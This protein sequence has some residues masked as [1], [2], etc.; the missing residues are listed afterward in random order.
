MM[1]IDV[2]WLANERLQN[3]ENVCSWMCFG[4]VLDV[5]GCFWMFLDVFRYFLDACQSLNTHEYTLQVHTKTP[6]PWRQ[7]GFHPPARQSRPSKAWVLR[8][9]L[10]FLTA[11]GCMFMLGL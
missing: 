11:N 9:L 4:C 8:V 5:F 10:V 2:L 3:V 1:F 7:G 6:M